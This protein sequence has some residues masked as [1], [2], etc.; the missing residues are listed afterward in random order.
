M[1]VMFTNLYLGVAPPWPDLSPLLQPTKEGTLIG[2]QAQRSAA[3]YLPNGQR[4]YQHETRIA[5]RDNERHAPQAISQPQLVSRVVNQPAFSTFRSPSKPLPVGGSKSLGFVRFCSNQSDLNG[6]CNG[7][8]MILCGNS[9]VLP[10]TMVGFSG[11]LPTVAGCFTSCF[12][13][14]GKFAG[15]SAW[16]SMVFM[17]TDPVFSDLFGRNS[18]GLS[19]LRR[20]HRHVITTTIL[21]NTVE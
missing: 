18:W 12:P 6:T 10:A 16:S 20:G 21:Y 2:E 13:S 7:H 11:D 9:A 1:G 5:H 14:D 17:G 3:A 8:V 15:N 19:D 4:G